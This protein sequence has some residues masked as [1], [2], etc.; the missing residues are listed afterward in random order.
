MK[1]KYIGIFTIN[2]I[3]AYIGYQIHENIITDLKYFFACVWGA[4]MIGLDLWLL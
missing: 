3:L 4:T 2:L 1:R